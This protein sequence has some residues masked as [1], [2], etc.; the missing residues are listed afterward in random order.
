M[1]TKQI[2]QNTPNQNFPEKIEHFS[3]VHNLGEFGKD[4]SFHFALYRDT[5]GNEYVC[6]LFKGKKNSLKYRSIKNEISAYKAL[7]QSSPTLQSPLGFEISI[8]KIYST[9]EN[10]EIVCFIMDKVSGNSLD[11]ESIDRIIQSYQAIAEYLL[12]FSI[13]A[14]LSKTGVLRRNFIQFFLLYHYYCLRVIL[15]NPEL[16]LKIIN[17]IPVFYR[18]IINFSIDRTNTLVIRDLASNNNIFIDNKKLLIIDLESAT[19]THPIIQLSSFVVVE[20]ANKD[21]LSNFCNSEIAKTIMENHRNLL[22][23]KAMLVYG[24]MV[25]IV[26]NYM[27]DKD[28]VKESSVNL[29]NETFKLKLS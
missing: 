4:S 18:G 17:T 3:F 5:E 21:F 11:N 12:K 2:K 24:A 7:N 20:S 28:P 9:Y 6:K 14:D 13:E 26:A 10:D 1:L 16:I 8:P 25:D 22:I 29:I 27:A 15:K 19:I 23:F